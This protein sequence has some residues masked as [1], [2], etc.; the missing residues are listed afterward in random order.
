VLYG[1]VEKWDRDY[2][3][4]ESVNTIALELE[5]VSAQNGKTLFLGRGEDY[6]SSGLSNGPTGYSS[7]AL[8][9]IKGLDSERIESLASSVIN[10]TLKP[11]TIRNS[12]DNSTPPPSISAS[13][14]TPASKVISRNKP[15]VVLAFGTSNSTAQ[16]SIGKTIT[17]VPMEERSPGH[18]FGEYVALPN[19]TF[20]AATVNVTLVDAYGRSTTKIVKLG[21]FSLKQ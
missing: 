4:L 11:L 9:P 3:G 20:D 7:L 2:Y 15:L 16:F 21:P 8:E 18:Y 1:R 13:S 14:V 12:H 17:N 19:D 6:V 10:E 5:L